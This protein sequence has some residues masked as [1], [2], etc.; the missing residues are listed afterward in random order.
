MT[1]HEELVRRAPS[2]TRAP[3][4]ASW[5]ADIVPLGRE[6][7]RGVTLVVVLILAFV[8]A[9]YWRTTLSM[10]AIWERSETFAHGFVVIPIFCYLLWRKRDAHQRTH[11]GPLL[12][13]TAGRRGCGLGLAGRRIEQRRER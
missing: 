10:A 1:P 7:S 13:R 6:R 11:P 12:G 8:L 5:Q 3:V 9:V 2:Q 4:I